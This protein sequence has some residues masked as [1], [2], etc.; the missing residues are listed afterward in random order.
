MEDHLLINSCL[1]QVCSDNCTASLIMWACT[2][3]VIYLNCVIYYNQQ[4][5]IIQWNYYCGSM[6]WVGRDII[7]LHDCMQKHVQVYAVCVRVQSSRDIVGKYSSRKES[8]LVHVPYLLEYKPGLRASIQRFLTILHQPIK[9]GRGSA[10]DSR[11]GRM[12]T[13]RARFKSNPITKFKR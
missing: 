10:C 9:S 13:R 8:Q 3:H 5:A 12:R 1:F 2:V 6:T 11:G 4:C 7:D